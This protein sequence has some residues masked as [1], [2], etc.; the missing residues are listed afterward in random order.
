MI[1]G[2]WY[3]FDITK[4]PTYEL[5]NIAQGRNSDSGEIII[6]GSIL[7]GAE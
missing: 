2:T 4:R 1:Y 7:S 6:Y 5:M 3:P